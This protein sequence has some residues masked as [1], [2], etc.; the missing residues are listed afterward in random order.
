MAR[1]RGSIMQYYCRRSFNTTHPPPPWG[2]S[3]HRPFCRSFR[4]CILWGA[5]LPQSGPISARR[6]R[7]KSG[8]S[9]PPA[10]TRSKRT[11]YVLCTSHM[12]H[13]AGR[14]KCRDIRFASSGLCRTLHAVELSLFYR[15]AGVPP[16][17]GLPLTVGAAGEGDE[18]VIQGTISSV[19]MRAVP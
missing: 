18:R 6:W 11:P 15:S 13:P 16:G 2:C 14:H 9:L 10:H 4:C 7:M 17:S 3:S 1:Q 8:R 12:S 5:R 19:S